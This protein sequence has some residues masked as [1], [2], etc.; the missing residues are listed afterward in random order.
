MSTVEF[1]YWIALGAGLGLLILSLLLGDVFD[2]FNLEIAGGDFAAAPVFFA[3]TA[4]FGAGGLIGIKGFEFGTG[5]SI[6]L[7]LGTGVSMGALTGLLF[8]A[9]RRQESV[10][11]F[12][13]SKLVGLRGRCTVA[14]GPGRVGRVT[15]QF[16]GM[17]RALTARS[18]EEIAVG[19][20]VVIQDVI[21]T[22]ITVARAGSSAPHA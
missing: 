16:A 7:G 22:T 17:S 18:G 5:G 12:E 1:A 9:L 2:F 21:G 8:F 11:G 4:A 15:V 19:E 14:V 20:E 3:A 10:E 6:Y 13:M